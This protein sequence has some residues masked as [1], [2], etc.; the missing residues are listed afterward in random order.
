MVFQDPPVE[1]KQEARKSDSDV[2]DDDEDDEIF[3]KY[4]RDKMQSLIDEM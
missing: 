1:K 4:K 3:Q 2:D